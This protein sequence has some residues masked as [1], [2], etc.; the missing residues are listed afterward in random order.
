MSKPTDAPPETRAPSQHSPKRR[1]PVD[2]VAL[3][4]GLLLM[5]VGAVALADRFGTGLDPAVLVGAAL[6][7]AG[8]AL[9]IVVA[10]R[11]LAHRKRDSEHQGPEPQDPER[12]HQDPEPRDLKRE[13][14]DRE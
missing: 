10:F 13:H 11:G 8:V 3:V 12:E 5:A 7:A 2:P 9:V 6:A 4:G 1:G 14:Q